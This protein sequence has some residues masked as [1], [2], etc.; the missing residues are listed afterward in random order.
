MKLLITGSRKQH[1]YK[2]IT[3]GVKKMEQLTG[4]KVTHVLHGGADGNDKLAKRYAETEKIKQTEIKPD[5]K[6]HYWRTAPLV[7]NKELVKLADYTLAIYAGNTRTGGTKHTA[8]FSIK[9]GKITVEMFT[10]RQDKI[11]NVQLQMF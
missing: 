2:R 5:Y 7:R 1:N 9:S 3:E 8:D 10:D 4:E 11:S 6:K